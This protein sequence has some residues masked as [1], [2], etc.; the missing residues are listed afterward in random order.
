MHYCWNLAG[1]EAY[2]SSGLPSKTTLSRAV[3]SH[4]TQSVP[5]LSNLCS[6]SAATATALLTL[7]ACGAGAQQQPATVS[8]PT[9]ITPP[10]VLPASANDTSEVILTARTLDSVRS[11]RD[12]FLSERRASEGRS[13]ALQDQLT[14]L[15]G[16]IAEVRGAVDAT[17]NREKAARRAKRAD[18]R[19]AAGVEKRKLERAVDLLDAQLDLRQAQAEEARMAREF[20]DASVRADDAELAIAER[21]AQVTPNDP[22]QRAAFQELTSRWLLALRTR[23]ARSYDL[24]DRRFKVIEAQMELLKRQRAP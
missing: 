14:T 22:S 12:R 5:M 18:E 24:E 2:L 9:G 20:F 8:P 19:T 17:E 7:F 10:Y 11:S 6:L 13:A 23:T 4:H 3:R 16:G 1:I 15:R 21:N